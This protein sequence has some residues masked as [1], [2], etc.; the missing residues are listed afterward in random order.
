MAHSTSRR[1]LWAQKLADQVA[2]SLRERVQ[3]GTLRPG[4]SPGTR[5][6]LMA[7]FTTS[8]SI[9]DKA[10]EDL[11][12]SGVLVPGPGGTHVVAE[13]IPRGSG[14]ELPQSETL[15]DVRSV[16]ELRLGLEAVCAALA[17]ERRSDAQLED[18]RAAAAAHEE[19]LRT[20]TGAAQA[21]LRFHNAI[22]AA[23]GNPYMVDLLDYLGPLL[24]PRARVTLPRNADD[25]RDEHHHRSIAEHQAI[26]AAI[27]DRDPDTARRQMRQHLLRAKALI[28]GID[29][30]Q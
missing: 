24:I 21:D 8:G 10:I 1:A 12:E 5:E 18:I 20:G 11:T 25:L 29:Q 3:T 26:V 27:A 2:N 9:I 22:A 28:E 7:E 14:F 30:E 23:S 19:T 6:E 16:L 4:A 17:A 15:A 13:V